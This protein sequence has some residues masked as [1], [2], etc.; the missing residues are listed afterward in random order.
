[1]QFN[2]ASKGRQNIWLVFCPTPAMVAPVWIPILIWR[3]LVGSCGTWRIFPFLGT[4]FTVLEH[5]SLFWANVHKGLV[6]A[7]ML[8]HLLQGSFSYLIFWILSDNNIGDG[9]STAKLSPVRIIY[10]ISQTT[11]TTPRAPLERCLKSRWL[12]FLTVFTT[13][14]GVIDWRAMARFAISAA[15]RSPFFS[16]RPDATM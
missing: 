13:I 11:T 4:F 10:T 5:F 1:M 16:G 8:S 15:W 14:V 3:R 7:E 12:W 2:R 9:G 6:A